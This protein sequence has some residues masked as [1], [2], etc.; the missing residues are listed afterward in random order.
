MEGIVVLLGPKGLI[1]KAYGALDLIYFSVS[2]VS[3]W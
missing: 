1:K 3:D 2:F